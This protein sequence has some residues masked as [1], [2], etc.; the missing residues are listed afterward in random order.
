MEVVALENSDAAA[1]PSPVFL[2]KNVRQVKEGTVVLDCVDLQVERGAITALI[3]IR[4]DGVVFQQ[5]KVELIG[6]Y[7]IAR[8]VLFWSPMLRE[9]CG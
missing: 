3:G 4:V 6:L 2:L 9:P 7:A 1:S 8:E 5:N